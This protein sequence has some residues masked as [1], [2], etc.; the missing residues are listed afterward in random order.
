M[1]SALDS[2]ARARPARPREM[3]VPLPKCA[4]ERWSWLPVRHV[5]KML[6]GGLVVGGV[7]A[8]AQISKKLRRCT[9][10]S[11]LLSPFNMLKREKLVLMTCIN[12]VA[13]TMLAREA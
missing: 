1:L 8:R 2:S 6:E 3:M 7:S 9:R 4:R 11:S 13:M 10:L 5:L 12:G